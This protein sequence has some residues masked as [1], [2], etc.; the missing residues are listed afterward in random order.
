MLLHDTPALAAH[1]AGS[2]GTADT[3]NTKLPNAALISPLWQGDACLGLSG[4]YAIVNAIRLGLA[5]RRPLNAKEVERL[6]A[7]GMRFTNGRMTPEQAT[8]CGLR[9]S[10]WRAMADALVE[11][12]CRTTGVRLEV[13][14]LMV[15]SPTDRVAAFATL[16]EALLR[17]RVP[18]ILLRGGHYTVVSG[19]TRSSLLL[20]DSAGA[21]WVSKRV[22]GVP[23]DCDGARHLIVP[24]S[25]LTLSV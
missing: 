9:I 6:F 5:D 17:L 7:T 24:A 1:W 25:F 15:Q 14:R 19:I 2:D 21:C 10:A 16:G 4:L 20:F 8:V 23:G 22:C 13:E 12:T 18:L 11:H 3:V